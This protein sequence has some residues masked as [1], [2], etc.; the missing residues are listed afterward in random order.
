M[1]A[2]Y[3]RIQRIQREASP[4]YLRRKGRMTYLPDPIWNWQ[5]RSFLREKRKAEK[6]SH[7][8]GEITID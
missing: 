7:Y 2:P 3:S 6:E 5:L 1:T 8:F 4:W